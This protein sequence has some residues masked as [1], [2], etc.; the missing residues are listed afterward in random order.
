MYRPASSDEPLRQA[1]I[2]TTVTEH[3]ADLAALREAQAP[4][5]E[6]RKH[7]YAIVLSQDCDL[8]LDH[9]AA[10]Q[11]TA[12]NKDQ[13]HV[14]HPEEKRI[15][16][17]LLCEVVTAE[18]LRG[19][20]SIN[21]K[22]WGNIKLNKDSRYHFL[23]EVTPEADRDGEGLQELGLDF[24]RFFT[25]PTDELYWQ[26]ESGVC[27]RRTVLEAPYRDHLSHRFACFLSRIGLP[28][29]YWST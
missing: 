19:N 6:R 15:P 18:E 17:I 16:T 3:R 22:I 2:L 23:S 14:Q 13:L 26:I 20:V 9:K 29:D 25:V 4:R 8:D 11:L 1:E 5:I 12:G 24:K 28:I 21:T 10:R 7:P 27:R